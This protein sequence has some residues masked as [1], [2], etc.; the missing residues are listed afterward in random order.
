MQVC[1]RVTQCTAAST[2][3][4]TQV[5]IVCKIYRVK[6]WVSENDVQ[7]SVFI[8]R[9]CSCWLVQQSHHIL[10]LATTPSHTMYCHQLPQKSLVASCLLHLLTVP[11]LVT[12]VGPT[13]EQKRGDCH[14]NDTGKNINSSQFQE[15]TVVRI[16][17]VQTR[18]NKTSSF[19]WSYGDDAGW[20][21]SDTLQMAR[22]VTATT[23]PPAPLCRIRARQTRS[24]MLK[25]CRSHSSIS[26]S[27]IGAW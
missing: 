5:C 19:C 18:S 14:T 4:C 9:Q 23:L 12:A 3:A 27:L 7:G 22:L 15:K 26:K 11:V 25:S 24:T 1:Q 6:T 13:M 21:A 16:P 8:C 20:L 17:H 10:S 2:T